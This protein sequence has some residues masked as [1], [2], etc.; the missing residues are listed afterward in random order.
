MISNSSKQAL[1]MPNAPITFDVARVQRVMKDGSPTGAVVMY[2]ATGNALITTEDDRNFYDAQALLGSEGV[3][4]VE[5]GTLVFE[6]GGVAF[7]PASSKEVADEMR[8]KQPSPD[9]VE[10]ALG[11]KTD[12]GEDKTEKTEK[13]ESEEAPQ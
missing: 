3:S 5:V 12:S 1:G 6:V 7:E 13:T 10:K 9:E 11:L 8:E 2:N 4:E